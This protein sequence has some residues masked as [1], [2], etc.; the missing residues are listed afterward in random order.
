M[1]NFLD[2]FNSDFFKS[3]A[4]FTQTFSTFDRKLD[5]ILQRVKFIEAKL[6]IIDIFLEDK[7]HDDRD[8]KPS[9]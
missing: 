3:A 6:N 8:H 4:E 2:M 5:D 1:N 7:N 9:N